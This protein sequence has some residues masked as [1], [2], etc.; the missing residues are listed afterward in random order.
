MAKTIQSI[1]DPLVLRWA[2]ETSGVTPEDAA[3]RVGVSA[4]TFSEWESVESSLRLS[5]LR[6]LANYFKRPLAALLLPEP[7]PEPALPSDFRS[8]PGHQ[9]RFDRATRL[10]IRKATRLRSV[11][12]DLMHALHRETVP[13]LEGI[14]L[15]EDPERVAER[16]RHKLGVTIEEQLQWKS[17]Y[18][19]LRRWRGAVESRNVLVLQLSI[20]VDDARGFS[21]SDEEPFVI[22]VSSSDA[23]HARIFTVF[24]EYAHLLLR[25]PGICLPKPDLH[26]AGPYAAIE[27]WCNRFAAA[28]LVPAK[29]MRSLLETDGRIDSDTGLVD[30]MRKGE[31]RFRVSQ[32][33]VLR[34]I[35]DAGLVSRSAFQRQMKRLLAHQP[36]RKAKGGRVEPARKCLAEHGHLFTSLVLEGKAAGM[37]NYADVAD[38]LDLRLKYLNK[39]ESD[40]SAAA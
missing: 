28:F 13:L 17:P 1:V 30:L 25:N 31:T 24:H 26:A 22:V 36:A 40:L 34:R 4:S 20:P 6:A 18:Q 16:E 21:L 15:S 37:V 23:V 3:K 27:Q 38:Y 9:S 12:T 7:P 29:A 19:A 8:L 11:A 2:R 39:V 32:Q 14:K 35:F 33:V 10:A 5:Q